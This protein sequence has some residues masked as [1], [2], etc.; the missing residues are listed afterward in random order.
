MNI[1]KKT[2]TLALDEVTQEIL[3][4][5]TLMV[6]LKKI[7][8]DACPPIRGHSGWALTLSTCAQ[9][10]QCDMCPHGLVWRK[11]YYKDNFIWGRNERISGLKK[12]PMAK[13]GCSREKYTIYAKAEELRQII[14]KSHMQLVHIRKTLLGRISY[15]KNYKIETNDNEFTIIFF[16]ILFSMYIDFG[17]SRKSIGDEL[18]A[19]R[20][21]YP[22]FNKWEIYTTDSQTKYK[23]K[24][25][26]GT[27]M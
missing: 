9:G 18:S 14:M 19:F 23:K 2:L 12:L 15:I 16:D 10:K 26:Q 4:W 21:T 3:A 25:S 11:Y 20:K 7:F 1:S 22:S 24:K 17:E 27:S 6:S 5:K 8:G 13:L